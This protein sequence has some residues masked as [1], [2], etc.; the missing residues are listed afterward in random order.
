ME[1]ASPLR[2]YWRGLLF[3]GEGL[4]RTVR[5]DPGVYNLDINPRSHNGALEIL[6]DPSLLKNRRM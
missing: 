3:E 6:V 1:R 2:N 4:S 5:L